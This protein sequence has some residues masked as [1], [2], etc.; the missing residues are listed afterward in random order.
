MTAGRFDKVAAVTNSVKKGRQGII[1][2]TRP[3]KEGAG[4]RLS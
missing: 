3:K 4:R 2:L 1:S